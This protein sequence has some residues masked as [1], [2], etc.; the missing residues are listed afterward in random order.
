M[1]V[2]MKKCRR[3]TNCRFCEKPIV[4]G[5]Y[6]VYCTWFKKTKD[7]AGTPQKWKF[8]MSFH[9]Q[10]WI[11]QAVIELEKAPPVETRGRKRLA[12]TDDTKE[13]RIKIL[14]RRGAVLQR[15]RN[16]LAKPE[17]DRSIDRIIHFGDK[18]NE[19]K[20]EIEPLGG[21]PSSWE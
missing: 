11:D 7:K 14:R 3:E 5:S 9:P 18:L 6:L 8:H 16:E 17:E 1:N 20:E 10:C 19:L 12:M 13:K 2:W 4:K 21:V 15:I